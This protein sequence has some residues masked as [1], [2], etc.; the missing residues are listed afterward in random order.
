MDPILAPEDF[1]PQAVVLDARPGAAS[2]MAGHLAGAIAADLNGPLSTAGDPGFDPA[3]GGRH[4][5]PDWENFA[6]QLG[7]WGIDPATEVVV[8]DEAQGAMGG[9]RLWW[10]LKALGHGPVWL[11]GGNLEDFKA[12]WGWTSEVSA[13][14]PTKPSYPHPA[15]FLPTVDLI[16]VRSLKD[17]PRWKLLDVRSAAR[18]RG[19]VEPIDPV[20]GRIPGALNL[21]L[22]ENLD[23]RGRFK[24]AVELR[25]LYL[26]FLGETPVDHLAVHCGS[27]VSACHTLLALERAGLAGASLYVGSFSEWCRSGEP[28]G[29]D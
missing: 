14:R 9:A 12:V 17:D 6:A 22:T 3:H 27:G 2:Y 28:L 18:W 23:A 13:P 16:Q 10:M 1:R 7:A 21:P 11:L 29:R 25:A 4:P 26:A 8:Y 15:R 24:S 5:L 20:A 19:E